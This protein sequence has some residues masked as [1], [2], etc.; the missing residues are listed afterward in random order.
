MVILTHTQT[1][2]VKSK[3]EFKANKRLAQERDGYRCVRCHLFVFSPECHHIVPFSNTRDNSVGNLMTL[4]HECH[5]KIHQEIKDA[6][7]RT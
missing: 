3:S 6:K 2:R 7:N 4:C 5:V 1:A